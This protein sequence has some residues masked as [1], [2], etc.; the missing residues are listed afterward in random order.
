M[1]ALCENY[2]KLPQITKF[3]CIAD[4][5]D[6]KTNRALSVDGANLRNGE[7]TFVPSFF[8]YLK[9]VKILQK[10]V[11][12]IYTVLFRIKVKTRIVTSL[13]PL[14]LSCVALG[15]DTQGTYKE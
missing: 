1:A 11:S 4:R 6:R 12:N 10:F 13:L 7:I 2:A 8:L 3:I 5:D 15:S 14:L 9:F